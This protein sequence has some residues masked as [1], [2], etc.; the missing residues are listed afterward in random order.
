M[1]TKKSVY[2]IGLVLVV[3]IVLGGNK[4]K[5]KYEYNQ[6][7]EIVESREVKNLIEDDL[8][9]FDKNALSNKGI[10]KEYYID[11]KS[12][13]KNPMGGLMFDIYVN[14]NLAYRVSYTLVNDL[15][16]KKIHI[17]ERGISKDLNT[18][19]EEK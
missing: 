16:D 2:I 3:G 11:K 15:P 10:I 8:K 12:I 18:L 17:G 19:F 13:K 1:S 7:V 4:L 9:Y 5:V 14:N 6:M